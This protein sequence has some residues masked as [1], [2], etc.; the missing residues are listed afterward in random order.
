MS[1]ELTE[2]EK[3][4]IEVLLELMTE[5]TML[6][7]RISTR[8]QASLMGGV[9]ASTSTARSGT[10]RADVERITKHKDDID[11]MKLV[12]SILTAYIPPLSGEINRENVPRDF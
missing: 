2:I 5:R 8:V 6:E 4:I 3:S 9:Q 11:N 1:D 12:P 10:S 7:R